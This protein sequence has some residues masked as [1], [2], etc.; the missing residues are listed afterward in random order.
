[1]STNTPSTLKYCSAKKKRTRSC[2][3]ASARTMRARYGR[4]QSQRT[5]GFAAMRHEKSTSSTSSGCPSCQVMPG[6]SVKV[7]TVPRSTRSTSSDARTRG[8]P[9][10]SGASRSLGGGASAV[11]SSDAATSATAPWSTLPSFRK[12][13]SAT[14]HPLATSGSCSQVSQ[15]GRT[16]EACSSWSML[17]AFVLF[18]SAVLRTVGRSSTWIVSV[19]PQ[20]GS[21]G[22]S[23]SGWNRSTGAGPGPMRSG[24]SR[25]PSCPADGIVGDG[26]TERGSSATPPATRS[27]AMT[28]RGSI[29]E[30][31][32]KVYCAGLRGR[33][34]R[35][36]RAR[37]RAGSA[38]VPPWYGPARLG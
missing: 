8:S 14:S 24:R 37:R 12:S 30:G 35:E 1:L 34:P 3:S 6:R 25:S 4:S 22:V 29:R 10:S 26:G 27:S 2:P 13:V 16:S 11:P 19:P 17:R 15:P 23:R 31:R 21:T 18:R 28:G 36:R 38:R 9:P 33:N 5:S 20:A 7:I 32:G